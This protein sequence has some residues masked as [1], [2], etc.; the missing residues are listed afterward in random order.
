MVKLIEQINDAIREH[1][2][3]VDQIERVIK[4]LDDRVD[5]YATINDPHRMSQV[6]SNILQDIT[7][8][9]H[10]GVRYMPLSAD[11]STPPRFDFSAARQRNNNYFH[12]AR[13]LAGNI[14]YLDFRLFPD[15][16]V[17]AETA[18]G[19]MSF[20]SNTDALIFDLRQNRGGTAS[21]I[22]L[23]LSYIFDGP[24]LVNT[25]YERT[26]EKYVQSWT[27][28]YVPGKK[29]V[30]VPVYVLISSGTG[31]AAEE[32]AYDIQQLKRG[33]LVG[34][35]SAGAGHTVSMITLDDG[36]VVHVPSGRPINPVSGTGWEGVGVIPDIET[37]AEDAL[38]I[39]HIHA[40][41]TLIE[42]TTDDEDLRAF[43]VW[44]LDNA[45]AADEPFPIPDLSVFVGEYGDRQISLE[46]GT[47][48]S[49]SPFGTFPLIAV[50]ENTFALSDDIRA[51]FDG[52]TLT[53]EWRDMPRKMTF[54]RTPVSAQ[55]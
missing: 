38:H 19:A 6:L 39:A 30:E 7:N 4:V 18:I 49:H 14:G 55:I 35:T 51:S 15:T 46:N 36:Y 50:N 10:F 20:L 16:S 26:D 34:Q 37:P 53:L 40:L 42:C 22:Q 41:E 24:T 44:E 3:N 9:K 12:E 54:D 52:N 28:P 27:M 25:F 23:L 33:T 5:E 47:L 29:M 45:K 11:T 1:Y 32:F 2:V 48:F 8:D 17:A 13:R 21:M 43:Y 31:S